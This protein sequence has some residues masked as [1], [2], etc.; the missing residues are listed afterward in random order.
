MRFAAC[1]GT[2]RLPKL[3]FAAIPRRFPPRESAMNKI[4]RVRK[5]RYG[6][7]GGRW[8]GDIQRS[9]STLEEAHNREAFDSLLFQEAV[10]EDSSFSAVSPPQLSQLPQRQTESTNPPFGK[11]QREE[12]VV[13]S[14]SREAASFSTSYLPLAS[15]GLMLSS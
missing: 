15:P 1:A 13:S 7:E 4:I 11:V 3:L 14:L 8:S 5:G 6:N 9:R 2:V 12:M 10:F